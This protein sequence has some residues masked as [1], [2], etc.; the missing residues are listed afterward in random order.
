VRSTA[1]I[2]LILNAD[3]FGHST[4][5][6]AAVVQAHQEGVLTSTSLKVTGDAAEEAVALACEVPTLAVGLHLVVVAGRPVLPPERIPHLVNGKGCFLDSPFRAGLR[7][8]F[9]RAAQEELAEELEAQFRRF[10]ATGLP[11][12]H[13]DGHLHMH[14]HPTVLRL[15]LPHA[16]AHGAQGLRL[17][18]DDL[19]FSLGYDQSQAGRRLTWALAFGILSKY[20]S[21]RLRH[22]PLTVPRRVYGLM[23]TGRMEEAYVLRILDRLQEPSAELYFHP[24]TRPEGERLGPN[25]GDLHA[26]LSPDVRRAIKERGMN[27][28]TYSTLTAR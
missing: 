16:M 18:R 9:S 12:S 27:L 23:Q 17:P 13:V 24:S 26:L 14:L 28:V 7:Y 8:F 5:V 10:I 21:L 1:G 22:M 4:G 20:C 25:P 6:N 19:W 2:Q 3:D 11:L 15:L